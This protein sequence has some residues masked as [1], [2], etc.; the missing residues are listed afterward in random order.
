MA[1]GIDRRMARFAAA[2]L[3]AR[4]GT[5]PATVTVNDLTAI[6][7]R[8]AGLSAAMRQAVISRL[9]G[10]PLAVLAAVAARVIENPSPGILGY[11]PALADLTDALIAGASSAMIGDV[12]LAFPWLEPGY[13]VVRGRP[14]EVV[15]VDRTGDPTVRDGISP[16]DVGQG[17]VA[18]CYLVAALIGIARQDPGLL[19]ERLRANPNGT[20]TII[21]HPRGPA[22]AGV[23]V[24][25]TASLP[26]RRVQ[27]PYGR[28]EDEAPG[29]RAPGTSRSR[30]AGY[31]E[32]AM[33]GDDAAGRPELWPAL[34]EKAYAR[35][36]GGYPAIEFGNAATA[37]RTLTGR[38][39]HVFAAH[40]ATV[41]ALGE[42]LADGEV[43]IVTTRRRTRPGGLVAAHAYT[44][45]AVDVARRR[46][47]LRNPWDPAPG[48]NNERW[49]AWDGILPDTHAV[50]HGPTR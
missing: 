46:V 20:V 4:I 10:R 49:Y 22:G 41:P 15:A 25:V 21:M 16:S 43:V 35:L 26:A 27:P 12:L 45:L 7:V 24:T 48:Q 32:V 36:H 13:P 8:L 39:A 40:E 17:G 44:L 31:E 47:L 9:R 18:D 2:E 1:R 30:A 3:V 28:S 14:G 37:L 38:S 5:D 42:L 29:P 33:D 6:S 50:V 11:L 19:A 34:Y 23:G